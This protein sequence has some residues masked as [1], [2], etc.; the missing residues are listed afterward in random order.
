MSSVIPSPQNPVPKTAFND[1]GGVGFFPAFDWGLPFF[2]GRTVLSGLMARAPL[3]APGLLAT[4]ISP[5]CTYHLN[6]AGVLDAGGE[7]FSAAGG[8][9]RINITAPPGCVWTVD[10]T[11]SGRIDVIG[12]LSG[13]GNG[14]LTYYITSNNGNYVGD[15]SGLLTIE[16]QTFTVEQESVALA[17][18]NFIG[19]M[20]HLAAE[21]NWTTMFTLV[22]KGAS[23]A[24]ARV[25]FFPT[26][27][28]RAS[29]DPSHCRSLFPRVLRLQRRFLGRCWRRPLTGRWPRMLR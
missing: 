8:T 24:Q 1:L 27:S 17:G 25:S 13:I 26:N 10:S 19:S 14:T 16:G 12:P 18:S 23:Q 20:P 3:L 9:G 11:H 28:I 21:E 5:D 22:N 4:S 6:V 15:W 29:M 2:F 7:T